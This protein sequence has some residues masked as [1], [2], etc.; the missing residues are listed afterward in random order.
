MVKA[1]LTELCLRHPVLEKVRDKLATCCDEAALLDEANVYLAFVN[2]GEQVAESVQPVVAAPMKKPES[3]P[4]SAPHSNGSALGKTSVPAPTNGNGT[5]PVRG[6]VNENLTLL[7]GGGRSP[8]GTISR[9]ADARRRR[10][11]RRG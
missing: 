3:A 4:V 2:D 8:E 11:A 6:P 7:T 9:V 1:K 10:G 5:P